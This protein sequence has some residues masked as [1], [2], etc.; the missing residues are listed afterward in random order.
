ML[1]NA[2]DVHERCKLGRRLLIDV[3]VVL[4]QMHLVERK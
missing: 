4:L 2:H 3:R 1:K